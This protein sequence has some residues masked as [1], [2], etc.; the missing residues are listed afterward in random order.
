MPMVA[1]GRG[2]TRSTFTSEA[3]H[4]HVNTRLRKTVAPLGKRDTKRRTVSGFHLWRQLE[5]ES[6][7]SRLK[8]DLR[9]AGREARLKPAHELDGFLAHYP[10]AKAGGKRQVG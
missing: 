10:P 6:R 2:L 4:C 7:E 8:A 1:R 3:N 5:P 9:T